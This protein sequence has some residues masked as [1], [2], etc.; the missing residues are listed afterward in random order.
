MLSADC[1]VDPLRDRVAE[2]SGLSDAGAVL[3]GIDGACVTVC[4]ND[5]CA[6]WDT[7]ALVLRDALPLGLHDGN[8]ERPATSQTVQSGQGSGAALARGQ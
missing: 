8:D 4:V 6:D 1:E 7:E 3:L 2:D 5:S